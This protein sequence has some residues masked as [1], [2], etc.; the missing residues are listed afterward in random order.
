[1]IRKTLIALSLALSLGSASAQINVP[2][3]PS[4]GAGGGGGGGA[5]TVTN[6][7]TA[8]GVSG[9][10]ITT[11][12]TISGAAV[13]RAATGTTDTILAADCGKVV[14]ES[15]AAAVA[16]TLPQ[17]TGS[18]AAPFFYTQV[19]LGAGTVTITPTT[20]TINGAATLVLTTG[21][22]AD[23]VSDGTNYIAALGKG[24]GAGDVVG[25]G[26]AT[27]NNFAVFNGTTGKIIKDG[28]TPAAVAT[29][30]SASDLGSG[31]LPAARLP[32][33]FGHG[34]YR[35]SGWFYGTYS[36]STIGG[37][38]TTA[39]TLYFY[40]FYVSSSIS[41]TSLNIWVSSGAGSSAWM[42][43]VYADAGGVPSNAAPICV[44]GSGAATTGS[45]VVS[46]LTVSC[47][48]TG[49]G[50]Y[51]MGVNL[52]GA[53]SALSLGNTA[54]SAT[55][56]MGAYLSGANT[57]SVAFG[58]G[59]PASFPRGLSIAHTY[60]SGSMPTLASPAFSVVATNVIPHVVIGN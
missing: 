9:G 60:A 37:A 31:T 15:N 43:G 39:N 27:A 36:G 42:A 17:A 25:P 58:A 30:G 55:D 40:P 5:G 28:G 48:I 32:S 16:V 59:A 38:T 2:I 8:C 34:S 3:G 20:S 35:T 51:W 56:T 23:I 21:Q 53:I 29:S 52:N 46:T 50:W 41:A 1:M 11:T 24:G 45:A 14:T 57:A 19:N 13:I 18:F 12:G 54:T 10:P 26:S 7:A 4:G 44:S 47:T 49:P 33:L 6:I 22:S